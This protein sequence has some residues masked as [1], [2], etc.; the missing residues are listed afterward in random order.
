MIYPFV[1]EEV[2]VSFPFRQMSIPCFEYFQRVSILFEK[3]PYP[4]GQAFI[5]YSGFFL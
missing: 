4:C 3:R 1:Y 2:T 5:V